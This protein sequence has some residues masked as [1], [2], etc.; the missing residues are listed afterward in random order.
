MPK[1]NKNNLIT[2]IPTLLTF[3]G[4]CVVILL[5]CTQF[6][7]G[8]DPIGTTTLLN[9]QGYT[10]VE[11]TG[12]QWFACGEGDLFSTGFNAINSNN[13]SVSGTVCRGLFKSSTIRFN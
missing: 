3:I 4:V 7:W 11:I 2:F 10:K 6:L 1:P 9:S 12:Y 8:I 5:V 13:H